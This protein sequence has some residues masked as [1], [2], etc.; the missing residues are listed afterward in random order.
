MTSWVVL[1]TI[2]LIALIMAGCFGYVA[3]RD[4]RRVSSPDDDAAARDAQH[5]HE[6]GGHSS[7]EGAW[8][9]NIRDHQ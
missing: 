4:R 8:L 6:T 3:W 9:R 1:G 5:W 2:A 7:R